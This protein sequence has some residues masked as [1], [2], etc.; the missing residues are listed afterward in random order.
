[1][2]VNYWYLSSFELELGKLGQQH[3]FDLNLKKIWTNWTV[4]FEVENL[5]D[6]ANVQINNNESNGNFNNVYQKNYNRQ[7]TLSVTYK[8]GNQ[9]I[10]KSRDI[11]EAN[12]TIKSR[13]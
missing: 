2:G 9:K 11:N 10:K 4:L 7:F 1:M 3:S 5:F 12:S 8:F 13:L 6:T